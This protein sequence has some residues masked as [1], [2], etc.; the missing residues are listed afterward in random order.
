MNKRIKNMAEK[1]LAGDSFPE[2][3]PVVIKDKSDL[4]DPI[5]IAEG[6]RDYLLKQP[7]DI[8]SN[9]LIVDRY[10]FNKCEYPSDYYKRAGHI[11][12]NKAWSACCHASAPNDLY[13]WGWTHLSLDYGLIL[14]QGLKKYIENIEKSQVEHRNNPQK[15]RLLEGMKISLKAIQERSLKY[16]D[17]GM[18]LAAKT[19]SN[20]EKNHYQTIASHCRKVPMYPA[21]TFH[22]AIQS[23]WTMFLINPDSLGRIDQYLYP[24]FRNETKQGTLSEEHALELLQE[25]FV[26]VFE[27][28]VDNLAL[29]IS[30]HNHLVVGGYLA[31]GS[32][33]YNPLS[34]LIMEA[35]AD[36][37]T[38]RPQV[39][40]RYTS[41]TTPETILYIT[42]LNKRCPNI[43]FVNDEPRIPGM[44]KG[45][46]SYEDAT[47][48]TVIGCNEW[49]ICGKSKFDLAHINLVHSLTNLLFNKKEKACSARTYDEFYA[50]YEESLRRDILSIADDYIAYYKEQAKDINVLTSALIE[51][52][53]KKA[54]SYTNGGPKYHG[55]SFSF[56][57]LSNVA[58]SLSV[59]KQ[60]VF[61]EKEL[62]LNELINVLEKD[63]R[64]SESIRNNILKNARFFGNDDDYV[65]SLAEDIV[66]S[67]FDTR[68]KISHPYL[69]NAFFGS[70]VGATQP[71]IT[72]GKKTPAT[73][74]G[75]MNGEGF[76]MG[77]SQS[78]GKD[79]TGMTA[80]LKSISKLDYS[81]FCGYI[82][83]NLKMD[84]KMVDSD[85]KMQRV[86]QMFHAFLKLGGMQLQINYIS[87]DELREAQKHPE[88]YKNLMVRVTGYS[89]FFTAFDKDLQ[90][91]IIRRTEYKHA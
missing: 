29:P 6:L 68:E 48:Y 4:E 2:P 58:D 62:K 66:N 9:E 35:I 39:S 20:D 40:F 50:M 80:L 17:K 76:T 34:A 43:V 25:L 54:E 87:T 26:K 10:R 24:Y 90:E 88:R 1:A 31:D 77:V 57:G 19:K 60:F 72:L 18:E 53:V 44:V 11:N 28:Q 73:P 42:K 14:S 75:R 32:D 3:V 78:F 55:L 49:A 89:G 46:I 59:I 64:D 51:D 70:F 38:Y 22:E 63:W 37:P 27:T 13:Y 86:A 8:R 33:G 67:I 5:R 71:N 65:D 61:E 81:K 79:K 52:C 45:G 91:D 47:E 74:D 15:N 36:L 85:E 7:I 69:K 84:P 16:A 23:V 41:K 83:S 30:G 12:T 56:N 21:E 82:V